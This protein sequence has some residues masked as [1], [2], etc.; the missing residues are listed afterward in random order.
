MRSR[1]MERKQ[2]GDSRMKRQRETEWERERERENV[3]NGRLFLNVEKLMYEKSWQSGG[4]ARAQEKRERARSMLARISRLQIDRRRHGRK[5]LYWQLIWCPPFY[6]VV[7]STPRWY[8]RSRVYTRRHPLTHWRPI[9]DKSFTF[10]RQSPFLCVRWLSFSRPLSFFILL[11]IFF[12]LS[13]RDFQRP[14]KTNKRR[15]HT[16]TQTLFTSYLVFFFFVTTKTVW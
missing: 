4:R 5:S 16:H 15:R 11:T 2:D 7:N 1:E 9:H 13:A 6:L 10:L 12:L 3:S 14:V 8:L